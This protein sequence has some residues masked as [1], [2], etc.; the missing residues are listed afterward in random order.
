L[1]WGGGEKWDPRLTASTVSGEKGGGPVDF[2]TSDEGKG[3]NLANIYCG[4]R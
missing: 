1:E 4:R 2:T 3:N